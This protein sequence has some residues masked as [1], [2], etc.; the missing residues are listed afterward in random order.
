MSIPQSDATTR[1]R[2]VPP[3]VEMHATLIIHTTE[4]AEGAIVLDPP[5]FSTFKWDSSSLDCWDGIQ[6]T[7]SENHPEWNSRSRARFGGD[8]GGPFFSKK[9]YVE[10]IPVNNARYVDRQWTSANPPRVSW[11]DYRGP[12]LPLAPDS[13]PFPP[14]SSSS[15]DAL[16]E[17]GTTAIAQC[18][19]TN[20]IAD[21]SV[22]LGEIMIGGLPTIIGSPLFKEQVRSAKGKYGDKRR[23]RAVGS[24]FLNLEFG[25]KPIVSDLRSFVDAAI[26]ANAVM[27]QYERDSGKVVRRSMNLPSEID[28]SVVP[29]ATNVSPWTPMSTSPMYYWPNVNQGQVFRFRKTERRR[30]FSGGFTYHMPI[31]YNARSQLARIA[32]EAKI[33]YGL[34]LTP[35]TV[36]NLTPW[37]WAVDWISNAG[38]VVSNLSDWA[39]DGLV[40]RYGY[41]MEH[42]ITT[43]TYVFSG[44]T[45]LMSGMTPT[46]VTTVSETKVRRRATPFGFGL[47]WNGFNPRQWAIITALGLSKS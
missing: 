25:W 39:T 18:K 41:V 17:L 20:A 14:F 22:F 1:Q 12:V 11:F 43:D 30:W 4:D 35:E 13:M 28:Q 19:P 38:D 40:L 36:W 32:A 46:A 29:V 45:G 27:K 23:R 42:S 10:T 9:S 33:V 44:L 8:C 47:D 2:V 7:V 37:S 15:N 24:E 21:A 31:G 16:D 5:G 34:S 26:R 6:V 3:E